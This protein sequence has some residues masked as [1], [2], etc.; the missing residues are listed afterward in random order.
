MTLQDEKFTT[1]ELA[2]KLKR[3]P[4]TLVRWRRLRQGPPYIRL[5]GRVLYDKGAV[6]RWLQ[7]QSVQAGSP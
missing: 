4:E 3:A 1:G 5:Q 6:E 2:L 7:D